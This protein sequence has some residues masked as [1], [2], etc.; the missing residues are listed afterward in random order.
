MGIYDIHL[1]DFLKEWLSSEYF[2]TA[3]KDHLE[4][5]DNEILTELFRAARDESLKGHDPARRIVDREH[6]KL[7]YQRNPKDIEKNPDAAKAIFKAASEKFGEENMRI[8]RYKQSS[9]GHEFPVLTGDERIVSSL[10]FIGNI[11]A[12]PHCCSG[13]CLYQS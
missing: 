8:D 9:K 2:H 3:L 11:K 5:T 13:L 1:K 7:L 6:F 10:E 4:L 12:R